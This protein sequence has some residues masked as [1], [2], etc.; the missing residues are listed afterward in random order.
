LMRYYGITQRHELLRQFLATPDKFT[1]EARSQRI[2]RHLDSGIYYFHLGQGKIAEAR[3]EF[4]EALRWDRENP[5]AR[6]YLERLS[7]EPTEPLDAAVAVEQEALNRR[8]FPYGLVLLFVLGVFLYFGFGVLE[9]ATRQFQVEKKLKEKK[10]R[11]AALSARRK[12]ISPYAAGGEGSRFYDPE[13]Y[14]DEEGDEEA[15]SPQPVPG[16]WV[17]LGA[18]PAGEEAYL[19]VSAKRRAYITINGKPYG[20]VPPPRAFKV[21]GGKHSITY[22]YPGYKAKTKSV[23]IKPGESKLVSVGLRREQSQ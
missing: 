8:L 9:T 1:R 13:L 17:Q 3:R 14:N 19:V 4:R 10:D 12:A 6:E 2:K 18:V 5:L 23:K 20:K 7:L 22:T 21:G 16:S 15:F 11:L